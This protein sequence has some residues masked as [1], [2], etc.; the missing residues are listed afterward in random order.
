MRR[1]HVAQRARCIVELAALLDADGLRHGD[2]H[3]IDVIAVPQRL[4]NRVGEPQHHDVL[5]GLFAE[6]V[7]DPVDLAL[8]EHGEDF[9]IERLRRFQIG[10][11][12]L[13]DDD[14]PPASIVFARQPGFAETGR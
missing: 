14:A 8:G 1:H 6:I 4:E 11:E 5:H 10:A 12:R 2:L 7:V 3:V 13:L 9:A